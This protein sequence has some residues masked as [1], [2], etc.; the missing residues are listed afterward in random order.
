MLQTILIVVAIVIAAL[1]AYA[2]TRPGTFRVQRSARI[3]AAPAT[4]YAIVNDFH[5]WIDWPPWEKLDPLMTR[6]HSG[7]AS[8]NGMVGVGRMEITESVPARKVGIK[9]DFIKPFE[10]HNIAEFTLVPQGDATLVNWSMHGPTPFVSKLM[11]VFVNLDTMVGKD[12]ESFLAQAPQQPP[13]QPSRPDADGHRTLAYRNV[14]SPL[15][16]QRIAAPSRTRAG[17]IRWEA[18]GA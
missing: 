10:G 8:G 1:L 2:A 4:L 15:P 18:A 16:A 9:L 17:L 14:S 6:A 7:A 13:A 12:F 5:R 11:Q 3:N